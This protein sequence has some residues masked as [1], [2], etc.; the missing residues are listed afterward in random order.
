M[1]KTVLY[2]IKDT[3]IYLIFKEITEVYIYV[4]KVES[5]KDNVKGVKSILQKNC[6]M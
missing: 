1:E 6:N 2:S 5:S 3:I 4:C